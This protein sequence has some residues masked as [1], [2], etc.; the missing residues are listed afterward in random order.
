MPAR[1]VG[2]E[3]KTMANVETQPTVIRG[4]INQ[5]DR[6]IGVIMFSA[7]T[8]LL[9]Y[10]QDLLRVIKQLQEA[11]QFRRMEMEYCRRIEMED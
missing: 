1:S 9:P 6:A 3:R 11:Y 5:I 10:D 4:I 8:E 7:E 2:L